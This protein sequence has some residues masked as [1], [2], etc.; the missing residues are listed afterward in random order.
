MGDGFAE[1]GGDSTN[2]EVPANPPVEVRM[3]GGGG[4]GAA[5]PE[6]KDAADQGVDGTEV[7]VATAAVADLL[8]GNRV[9]LGG[10]GKGWR[11]VAWTAI[12][13]WAIVPACSKSELVIVPWGLALETT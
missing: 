11:G 2:M 4:G 13:C 6:M 8:A 9:L 12:S 1:E 5:T 10:E 7:G 3:K